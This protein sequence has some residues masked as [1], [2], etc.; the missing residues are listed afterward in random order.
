MA[1]EQHLALLKQGVDVWNNWREKN[2][3]LD[4]NLFGANLR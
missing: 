1:D 3:E 2:P 4:P